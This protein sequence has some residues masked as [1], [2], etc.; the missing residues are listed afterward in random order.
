MSREKGLHHQLLHQEGLP[1][2]GRS[3][4]SWVGRI[5]LPVLRAVA[6]DNSGV[7]EKEIKQKP[8]TKTL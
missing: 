5:S 4:D 3:S 1:E 7:R 2:R 6:P 8:K